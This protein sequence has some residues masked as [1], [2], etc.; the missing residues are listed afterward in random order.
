MKL[1]PAN[2]TQ[3]STGPTVPGLDLATAWCDARVGDAL[4]RIEN[5]VSQMAG[6]DVQLSTNMRPRNEKGYILFQVTCTFRFP[7]GHN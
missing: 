6:A 4:G 5:A 7:I 1:L 3:C 2:G